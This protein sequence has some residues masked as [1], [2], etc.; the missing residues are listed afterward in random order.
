MAKWT[1]IGGVW[2]TEK[3]G[4]SISIEADKMPETDNNGKIKLIAFKNDK[5][6]GK[7]PDYRILIKSEDESVPF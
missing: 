3:G 6:E 5:K 2:I 1:S 4:L 7:Q